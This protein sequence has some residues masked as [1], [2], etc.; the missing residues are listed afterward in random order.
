M[1]H[2][3][4]EPSEFAITPHHNVIGRLQVHL[5]QDFKGSCQRFGEHGRFV[6]DTGRYRVEIHDWNSHI[7]S[8]TA[9]GVENAHDLPRW[10]VAA[11]P[12]S[13]DRATTT[14][15]VDLSH[16][17]CT[18]QLGWSGNDL[19]DKFVSRYPLESHIPLQNLQVCGT[20]TSRMHTHYGGNRIGRRGGI[21][22]IQPQVLTVPEESLHGGLLVSVSQLKIAP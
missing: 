4:A 17:P 16:H 2:L 13:T 11:E 10:T 7:L 20:N 18:H 12:L 5:F 21:G 9:I 8:K 1:Q 19:A 22:R 15:K 3:S 14:G 6:G